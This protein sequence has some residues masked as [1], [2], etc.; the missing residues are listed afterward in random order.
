MIQAKAE[1]LDCQLCTCVYVQFHSQTCYEF[2][3]DNVG[4]GELGGSSK[5]KGERENQED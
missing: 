2:A 3:K 5:S 4:G 1:L